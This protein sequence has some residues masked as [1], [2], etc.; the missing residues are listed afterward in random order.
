MHDHI[1]NTQAERKVCNECIKKYRDTY[2]YQDKVV[3]NTL[4]NQILVKMCV[5]II[6]HHHSSSLKRNI[7]PVV[8]KCNI[9]VQNWEIIRHKYLFSI[10]MLYSLITSLILL[11]C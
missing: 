1:T 4:E 6:N 7:D 9:L 5:F 10:N 3:H 2:Y 11:K 8:V